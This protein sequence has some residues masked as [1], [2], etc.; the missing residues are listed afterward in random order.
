MHS[1]LYV[2]RL[3][4][5]HLQV[6]VA[7]HPRRSV[8]PNIYMHTQTCS[9]MHE[10]SYTHTHTTCPLF[11]RGEPPGTYTGLGVQGGCHICN[12]TITPQV[13]RTQPAACRDRQA[14]LCACMHATRTRSSY[15]A[16][17]V[18]EK[19][20]RT[21]CLRG[22]C[23]NGSKLVGEEGRSGKCRRKEYKTRKDICETSR[24]HSTCGEDNKVSL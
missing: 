4:G 18:I 13:Q 10:W 2:S 19:W 22:C 9:H 16:C 1:C 21:N 5:P 11:R 15:H 17:F 8:E 12:N 20:L 6:S 23:R 7:V 14:R 3:C 24:C